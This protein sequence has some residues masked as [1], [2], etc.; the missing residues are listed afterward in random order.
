MSSTQVVPQKSTTVEQDVKQ[1]SAKQDKQRTIPVTLNE[2][3][4]A[5]ILNSDTMEIVSKMYTAQDDIA[6]ETKYI[7]TFVHSAVVA[8]AKQECR[9]LVGVWENAITKE[10]KLHPS[11]SRERAESELLQSKKMQE[12]KALV[13]VALSLLKTEFK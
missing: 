10:N 4:S 5:V 2:D 1:A 13:D 12:L 3:Q 7:R 6:N 11:W 9:R 8:G